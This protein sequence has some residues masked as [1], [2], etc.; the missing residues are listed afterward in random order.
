MLQASTNFCKIGFLLE[1]STKHP[2]FYKCRKI[3]KF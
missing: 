1:I 2:F 3:V